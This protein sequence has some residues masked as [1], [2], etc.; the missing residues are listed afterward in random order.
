MTTE[1][2]YFKQMNAMPVSVKARGFLESEGLRPLE[3][4][5]H[6][7]Q[8]A[9]GAIDLGLVEVETDVAETVKAMMDWK[10]QRIVNFFM[11][12]PGEEYEPAGWESAGDLKEMAAVVLD[13]IENRM[14][15][16]F[17]YYRSPES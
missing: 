9:F 11:L 13:D 12:M 5:F 2:D 8:M 3:G 17:P 16:H 6:C 15:L 14:V 7:V 1:T 4:C 10:P